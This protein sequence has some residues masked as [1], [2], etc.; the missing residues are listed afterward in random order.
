MEIVNII[1]KPTYFKG[2]K[3]DGVLETG[4]ELTKKYPGII[5]IKGVENE[6]IE[7]ALVRHSIVNSITSIKKDDI[8]ITDSNNVI[9]DV[10]SELDFQNKYKVEL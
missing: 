9:I 8:I 2:F 6:F 1:E 5:F 7:L 3:F 4:I 10:V